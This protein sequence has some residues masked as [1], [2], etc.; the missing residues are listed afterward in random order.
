MIQDQLVLNLI[1]WG[2]N[3][4]FLVTFAFPFVIR[5]IWAWEKHD[6]GWNIMSFDACVSSAL[7]PY[8]IHGMFGVNVGT[9]FFYWSEIVS[10][11]LIPVVVF[12][13][14][15]LIYRKQRGN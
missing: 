13:R 3:V 7:F 6:W 5:V 10:I 1:D 4:A 9:T 11:W 15:I 8:F 12:W 14:S 2:A